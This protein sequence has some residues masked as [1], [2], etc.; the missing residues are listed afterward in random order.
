MSDEPEGKKANGWATIRSVPCST[1][2]PRQPSVTVPH[3][4][5]RGLLG[6]VAGQV[7]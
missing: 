6:A 5:V 7:A 4:V 3:A 2:S 1:T